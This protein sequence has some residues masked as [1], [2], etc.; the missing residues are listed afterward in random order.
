M[1]GHYH[2]PMLQLEEPP[3]T[4]TSPTDKRIDIPT[5]LDEALRQGYTKTSP[6]P[7]HP[8]TEANTATRC[9]VPM[10]R[11]MGVS[12]SDSIESAVVFHSPNE[13]AERMVA[14]VLSA[15]E[16]KRISSSASPMKVD[17][18]AVN[19]TLVEEDDSENI[20]DRDM[21]DDKID[22][23]YSDGIV[24]ELYKPMEMRRPEHTFSKGSPLPPAML[25][26]RLP[27]G[28][29][30]GRRYNCSNGSREQ[31]GGRYPTLSQSSR[32]E[33]TRRLPLHGGE[34]RKGS[35]ICVDRTR[36]M[37]QEDMVRNSSADSFSMDGAGTAFQNIGQ[38][39]R[40]DSSMNSQFFKSRQRR[41]GMN[42]SIVHGGSHHDSMSSPS[43][44]PQVSADVA[45]PTLMNLSGP[46]LFC[47]DQVVLISHC[48]GQ[49]GHTHANHHV[50]NHN[51]RHS[52]GDAAGEAS[53]LM[54]RIVLGM[55]SVDPFTGD[56]ESGMTTSLSMADGFDLVR[57]PI[58]GLRAMLLGNNAVEEE[59][60]AEDPETRARQAEQLKH[61][62]S[63]VVRQ[64]RNC[65]KSGAPAGGNSPPTSATRS[66]STLHAPQFFRI[67]DTV[68]DC[69]APEHEVGAPTLSQSSPLGDEE[70]AA[71]VLE[72][73]VAK[74]TKKR[75]KRVMFNMSG[76]EPRHTEGG[77]RPNVPHH[78]TPQPT[79]ALVPHA[80]SPLARQCFGV[81]MTSS[82]GEAEMNDLG[83]WDSPLLPTS[84]R[85]AR[86]AGDMQNQ[87]TLATSARW[88][89]ALT[90]SA[91]GAVRALPLS[92]I[93][94]RGAPSMSSLQ[95]SRCGDE[96][97]EHCLTDRLTPSASA[98]FAQQQL[99][100]FAP[101]A[102]ASP[103]PPAPPEST[104]L[105]KLS[106]IL[107]EAP[108]KHCFS[109]GKVPKAS[110]KRREADMAL[111]AGADDAIVLPQSTISFGPQ[112][113]FPYSHLVSSNVLSSLEVC[114]PDRD[115]SRKGSSRP[116]HPPQTSLGISCAQTK[117][118]S[119]LQSTEVGVLPVH[120][121]SGGTVTQ[122]FVPPLL[123]AAQAFPDRDLPSEPMQ[124]PSTMVSMV[125][126]AA[127]GL[128]TRK[129]NAK[130]DTKS[131]CNSQ[132]SSA[133]SFPIVKSHAVKT[134]LPLLPAQSS[135]RRSRDELP[136][137]W[138]SNK[139]TSPSVSGDGVSVLQPSALTAHFH[140]TRP[141]RL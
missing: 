78:G 136:R 128:T 97:D 54:D 103:S 32:L 14:G 72:S 118:P 127:A 40:I 88:T 21:E 94:V 39:Q 25:T 17:S 91:D 48:R 125:A 140:L 65:A 100:T 34:M 50:H 129:R 89:E 124:T 55:A 109:G 4:P 117:S 90:G 138:P 75:E 57:A 104:T 116:R 86:R 92:V 61:F 35:N 95:T 115:S 68:A 134:G 74:K 51:H 22:D 36:V 105:E 102:T 20:E 87:L 141:P 123:R 69:V 27:S 131:W 66:V 5:R 132:H 28:G 81:E 47:S 30:S 60:A 85:T 79:C 49:S 93:P 71:L 56:G 44:S 83:T 126:T 18:D 10:R 114:L 59:E 99:P 119:P 70:R 52:D 101:I 31:A 121:K 9:F 73:V 139:P 122:V 130:V 12:A 120:H 53:S 38:P 77:V 82:C 63:K 13:T 107:A 15:S 64:H 3:T 76:M 6:N 112:L 135:S 80:P 37:A 46:H 62:Y 29:V 19:V 41:N 111:A 2:T 133:S 96:D 45:A 24:F 16:Q 108:R 1:N 11:Y 98:N 106:V 7:R 84:L 23:G 26:R 137:E 58:T 43:E 33:D 110:T 67:D 42:T 113:R 8:F